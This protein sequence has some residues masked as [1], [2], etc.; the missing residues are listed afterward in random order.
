MTCHIFL[1]SRT[2]WAFKGKDKMDNTE[3]INF[4]L[5]VDVKVLKNTAADKLRALQEIGLLLPLIIK[6]HI[7]SA[8]RC[9][10]G[11]KEISEIQVDLKEN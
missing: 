2:P 6:K 8:G 7:L 10:Y 11:L 4:L 9:F 1:I 5:M 3:Y